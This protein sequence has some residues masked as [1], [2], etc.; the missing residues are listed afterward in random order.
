MKSASIWTCLACAIKAIDIGDVEGVQLGPCIYDIVLFD[1][2]VFRK[3]IEYFPDYFLE[4]LRKND[5]IKNCH[6]R[7]QQMEKI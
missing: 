6:K 3:S 4:I 7:I 5:N 2:P 1:F